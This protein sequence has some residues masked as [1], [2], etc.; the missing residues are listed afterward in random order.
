MPFPNPFLATLLIAKSTE[1]LTQYG[2]VPL[3]VANVI[4]FM[5]M[6]IN[7]D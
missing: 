4:I 6:L 7:I 5:L 1:L 3:I 2:E